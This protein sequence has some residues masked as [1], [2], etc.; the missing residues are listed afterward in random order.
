MVPATTVVRE[1]A[2]GWR[3]IPGKEDLS[4]DESVTDERSSGRGKR[5][6]RPREL[7][8]LT[9]VRRRL[10]LFREKYRG[11]APIPVDAIVGSV[12][13]STQFDRKFRPKVPEQRERARQIALA[14]PD[15]DFPPI[16]VYRI[17]D[18]YFVRDGHARVAAAV[19]MKVEFI[20]AEITDLETDESI[21]EDVDMMDVIHLQ[22]RRRLLEQTELGDARPE[23]D[24]RVSRPA[25]YAAIRES[26]A[27]HGY[28]I[29]QE[30]G[31][32]L[33]RFDVAADWYDR[34]Y[35]PTIDAARRSGIF[36]SFP[37]STETDLFLWL[38]QRR[39]AMLPDRGHLPLE[40]VALEVAASG[41]AQDLDDDEEDE[42]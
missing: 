34:V 29:I 38:E 5:R 32:L 4:G 10:M 31:E 11:I 27:A 24:L 25:G 37:R 33:T 36:E 15:G 8:E 7:V 30:R 26:I 21:P 28:W 12:D 18:V 14:Y 20:D 3:R 19:S 22:Q 1:G 9:E 17:S 35:Q 16:K 23:A 41:V 40:D 42:R 6:E 2:R 13:R 39:R